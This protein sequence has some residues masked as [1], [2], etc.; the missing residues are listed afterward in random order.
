ML[1]VNDVGLESVQYRP[2]PLDDARI[3]PGLLKA[4]PI[5]IL[6]KGKEFYGSVGQRLD[7]T[8]TPTGVERRKEDGDVVLPSQMLSDSI[9]VDFDPGNLV[10][11]VVVHRMQNSHQSS[12]AQSSETR[13]PQRIRLRSTRSEI[14]EA[15]THRMHF[16]T[17]T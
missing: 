5:P 11:K 10:G 8:R 1:Y 16:G 15:G 9:R 7:G 2:D 17:P 4:R 12:W 6:R 13:P 3:V 14:R